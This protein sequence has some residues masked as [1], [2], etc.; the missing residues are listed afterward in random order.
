[1]CL[2]LPASSCTL[3]YKVQDVG[4]LT[5]M[6]DLDKALADITA[7]RSQM[8]RGAMFRG[9]GPMTIAATGALAVL[10]GWVQP[11]WVP[12]PAVMVSTAATI[13][14]RWATTERA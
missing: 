10:A 8:A 11:Y 14:T 9:Y 1:M 12:S 3:Q 4:G 2:T 5:I 7:I 13:I 6:N